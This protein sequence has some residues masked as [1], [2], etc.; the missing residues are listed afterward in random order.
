VWLGDDLAGG[1]MGVGIGG[2]MSGDSLFGRHPGAAA[3]AVADMS[4]RLTAAGGV[5]I[6]AQWDSPFLRSLGARP[7]PRDRYLELLGEQAGPV[8]LPAGSLPAGR[9]L[10]LPRRSP[11]PT[12]TCGSRWSRW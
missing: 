6:D 1:A 12:A 4:A 11:S 10:G 7:V 8:P 9:L 5:F 2:V 3:I